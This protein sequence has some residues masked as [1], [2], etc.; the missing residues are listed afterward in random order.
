MVAADVG[1]QVQLHANLS[2]PA[3]AAAA[4]GSAAAVEQLQLH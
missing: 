2:M 1:S 4:S 3:A